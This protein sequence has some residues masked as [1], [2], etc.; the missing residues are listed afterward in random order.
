MAHYT[1]KNICTWLEISHQ[2]VKTWSDEFAR[3]LSPDA[4]P[5]AGKTRR[6]TEEDVKVFAL[7]AS[8]RAGR[9]KAEDIHASLA[10]GS[11]GM[12]PDMRD[13][14]I[15]KAMPM[16]IAAMQETIGHLRQDLRTAQDENEQYKGQVELLKEM[17][18]EKETQLQE[19]YQEV[20]RLKAAQDTD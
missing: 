9:E 3:Y 7:V 1:T 19:M 2:T 4:K 18:K 16:Q 20:A 8:M 14:S 15:T 10:S 6:F 11:R 13:S 5:G 12:L 17:L